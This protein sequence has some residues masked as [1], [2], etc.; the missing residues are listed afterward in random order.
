MKAHNLFRGSNLK[1]WNYSSGS[2]ISKYPS[3]INVFQSA[4][5]RGSVLFK[6]NMPMLNI[7]RNF[8]PGSKHTLIT[9]EI[10]SHYKNHKP[11]GLERAYGPPYTDTKPLEVLPVYNNHHEPRT[12]GDKFALSMVKFFKIF[13]QLFFRDKYTH[14]AVVL[15]TVAA[16]PGMIAAFGRHLRSLRKMERDHGWIGKLLEE[17]ENERMHLLTW[18]QLVH[19]TFFE[20]IVV[21]FAQ[22]IYTP[23]YAAL[24]ILSPKTA[25]RFVGYLEEVACHEYTE[26]LKAIDNGHIP[27]VEAPEIAKKYWNLAP[28]ARLR[29]V[30]L[31]VRGDEAMHRDVNHELSMKSRVGL[32]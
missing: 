26:F 25:H 29:D 6:P 13:T 5:P 32:H 11:L 4:H 7:S 15:E 31:V 14:H 27:N 10:D 30:V 1:I 2:R 12:F 8:V 18:M 28:D 24:Y 20:R 22:F 9:P 21:I 3:N 17:A 19:P 16:V 23:F